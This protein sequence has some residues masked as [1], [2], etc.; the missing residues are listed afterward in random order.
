MIE[1]TKIDDHITTLCV[2]A[3]SFPEGVL[4][5]HQKL[6]SLV[7]YSPARKYFG[8]SYPVGLGEIMYQAATEMAPGDDADALDCDMFFIKKG[9]YLSVL[10]RNFRDDVL[11]IGRIFQQLLDNP[12]IDPFGYCLEWYLNEH[13]V[14]CM[15]RLA[16]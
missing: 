10:I 2:T 7:E 9:E 6:H 11:S 5:A 15:V 3:E 1:I 8:I 16:D 14:R 13:D 12:R 4:A